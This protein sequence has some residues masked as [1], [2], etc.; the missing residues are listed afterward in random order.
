MAPDPRRALSCDLLYATPQWSGLAFVSRMPGGL[1]SRPASTLTP[2]PRAGQPLRCGNGM[3]PCQ[4]GDRVRRG[5]GTR[6]PPT[7]KLFQKEKDK[8]RSPTRGLKSGLGIR[9]A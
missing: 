7:C 5:F 3:A 6:L 4:V 8:F 1:W 2:A 9:W